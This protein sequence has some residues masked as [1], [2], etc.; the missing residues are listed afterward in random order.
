MRDQIID[1]ALKRFI[2]FGIAKTSLTEVAGDPQLSTQAL[3]THFPD[4]QD[5]ASTIPK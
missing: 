4:K 3:Y 1:A 5:L 2:Q